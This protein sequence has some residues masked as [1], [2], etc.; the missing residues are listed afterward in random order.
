MNTLSITKEDLVAGCFGSAGLSRKNDIEFYKS[1]FSSFLP[2]SSIYLCSDAEILLAGG[3]NSL[4]GICLIGGTGSVCFGRSYDGKIIRS[5][6]FGWRL[7]DEGSGWSIANQAIARTLKSKELRDLPTNLEKD[8]LEFFTL[9][10]IEDIISVVNDE[11]TTKSQI[12]NFAKHVTKAGDAGDALALSILNDAG[13]SLFNLVKS[14]VDRLP[15]NHSRKVVIAGGVLKND[16]YVSSSFYGLMSE[17]LSEYEV[18]SNPINSAVD[19]AL[20][21]ASTMDNKKHL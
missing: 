4:S 2:S 11:S 10:N 12:G 15:K 5:G 13:V 8:I 19:G 1:I 21:L 17:C 18:I 7:G 6:G 3:L 16:K 14:V 9:E 20:L